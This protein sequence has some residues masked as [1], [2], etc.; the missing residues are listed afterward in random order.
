MD[1]TRSGRF[2]G[3][4]TDHLIAAFRD[5]ADAI[6][7]AAGLRVGGIRAQEITVLRGGEGA[8]RLDGTG[9]AH[10]LLARIRRLVSFTLMDQLPDMAW[11]ERSVRDGGAVV[12]VRVRGDSAKAAAVDVM[13]RHDGHFVNYYGRFSTEE[14]DRWSGPEPAVHDLLKR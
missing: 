5:P 7:A 8:D 2:I 11:Y 6:A 4:P 14:I 12:M 13:R 9:A 3:Y 10:G 1:S